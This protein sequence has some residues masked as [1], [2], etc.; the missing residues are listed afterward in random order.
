M[1]SCK[2][3]SLLSRQEQIFEAITTLSLIGLSKRWTNLIYEGHNSYYCLSK[4]TRQIP[5]LPSHTL[6]PC[7]MLRNTK[8]GELG[9]TSPFSVP[10]EIQLSKP[11]RLELAFHL[12]MV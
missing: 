9:P 11:K 4:H 3:R 6:S 12:L 5:F 10:K 2:M 8:N 1:L 7:P